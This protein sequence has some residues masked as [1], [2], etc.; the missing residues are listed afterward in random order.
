[1]LSAFKKIKI[2]GDQIGC[3][4]DLSNPLFQGS[5]P[6]NKKSLHIKSRYA[7][8][9]DKHVYSAGMVSGRP[10][11]FALRAPLAT[12]SAVLPIC[13]PLYSRVQFPNQ[14]PKTKK[15][16]ISRVATLLLLICKLFYLAERQG[17]E[18]WEGCPSTV[19]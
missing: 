18:P 4:T 17:F 14:Y 19:F 2:A 1:M 10:W 16:Y 9:L 11:P 12:K 6:K 7:S 3:P 13:R 8:T 15:A 5:I